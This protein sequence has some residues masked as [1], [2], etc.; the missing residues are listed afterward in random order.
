[1][2]MKCHET[3]ISKKLRK[4]NIENQKGHLLPEEDILHGELES[5]EFLE[6]LK[7]DLGRQQLFERVNAPRRRGVMLVLVQVGPVE[8]H[9][10]RKRCEK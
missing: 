6:G 10:L 3:P 2:E 5:K 1:M 7:A 4:Q 9:R 8:W